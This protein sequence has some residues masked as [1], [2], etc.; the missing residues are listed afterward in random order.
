M[1]TKAHLKK[2]ADVILWGLKAARTGKFKKYDNILIRFDLA[3][4][5]LAEIIQA[6]NNLGFI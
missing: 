2:Y 3:A 5:D 1:L 6:R 4:K